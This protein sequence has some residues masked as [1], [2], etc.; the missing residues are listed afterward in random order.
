LDT[1]PDKGTQGAFAHQV[2]EFDAG[3]RLDIFITEKIESVQI[4]RAHV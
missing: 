1:I 4:G 2:Y 3:K